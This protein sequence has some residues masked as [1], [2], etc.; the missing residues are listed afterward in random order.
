MCLT[1]IYKYKLIKII[2]CQIKDVK[3][4]RKVKISTLRSNSFL[5]SLN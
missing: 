2:L 4:D 5:T 1:I 3:N